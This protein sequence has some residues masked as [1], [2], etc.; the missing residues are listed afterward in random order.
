MSHGALISPADR[1]ALKERVAFLSQRSAYPHGP[2]TVTPL[3][4]H[5]SWVFLAP[6]FVYKLKKP[7]K[8]PFLDYRALAER[9]RFC[10]EELA[11]NQRLGGDTYR[12]ILPVTRDETGCFALDGAGEPVDWLV[13][14][15]LLDPE[16]LL[17]A[18]LRAGTVAAAD[19]E[20]VA[21]RLV[22]FY[23]KAAPEKAIG[24]V[25]P[26][27]LEEELEIC[28][29]LFRRS[30]LGLHP[31]EAL[32]LVTRAMAALRANRAE[33]DGRIAAG[34][35]VEGHGD[36]RPEHVWLGPETLIFD[37]LDFD[38]R[39]RIIDPYDEAQYLGLEAAVL[40]AH[41][42]APQLLAALE[43]GIG[44]PPSAA[45]LSTYRAF[46]AV[47]RARISLA[48]LLDDAPETPDRWPRDARAYLKEA[49]SAL[50][51]ADPQ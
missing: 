21:K 26:A 32:P 49:E 41:W 23:K 47:L 15:R 14:M 43:T 42:V 2:A 4:T 28:D 19:I 1:A 34:F 7:V 12:R 38:R 40:G 11:I 20:R 13:E 33:L 31:D 10:A 18:R 3:E 9:R 45:L 27:H 25:Y 24:A 5:M 6:P 30:D 16:N 51:L 39:M 48:H 36:L 37:S 44:H 8:Y 29:A 50:K 46:R 17:D 22:A 35:I